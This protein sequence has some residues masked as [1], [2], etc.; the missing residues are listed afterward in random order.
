M[1]A[2][3]SAVGDRAMGTD[4]GHFEVLAWVRSRVECFG[5]YVDE[6]LCRR[7]IGM[8]MLCRS[9]FVMADG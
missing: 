1:P 7:R 2:L 5:K 3:D 8:A 6:A 9:V 4:V